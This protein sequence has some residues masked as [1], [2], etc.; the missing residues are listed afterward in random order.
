[1]CLGKGKMM[2]LVY[3]GYENFINELKFGKV[4]VLNICGGDN[5]R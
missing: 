5:M 1:M 3:F 2:I 4:I